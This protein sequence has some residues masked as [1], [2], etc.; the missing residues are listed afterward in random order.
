MSVR[1]HT[2]KLYPF[3][4]QMYWPPGVPLHMARG[5]LKVGIYR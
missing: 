5:C 1:C 3:R 4:G 2:W